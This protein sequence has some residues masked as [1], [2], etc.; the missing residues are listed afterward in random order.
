MTIEEISEHKSITKEF[1]CQFFDKYSVDEFTKLRC[2]WM[3][4]SIFVNKKKN[5][6][7]EVIK[8]RNKL[9]FGEIMPMFGTSLFGKKFQNF[10]KLSYDE[11]HYEKS[12]PSQLFE[13][14][15]EEYFRP[16]PENKDFYDL[17]FMMQ[18]KALS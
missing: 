5:E 11:Y 2:F 10:V 4:S 18:K 17:T 8:S 7:N 16:D 13:I 1:Q 6:W 14:L 9:K 3:L 12:N 15:S